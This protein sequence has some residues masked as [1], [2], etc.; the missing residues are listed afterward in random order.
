MNTRQVT[1]ATGGPAAPTRPDNQPHIRLTLKLDSRP[2]GVV[3]GAWWPHSRVLIDELPELM[4]CLDD[5]IGPVSRVAYSLVTWPAA[6]RRA[7]VGGRIVRLGGFRSISGDVIDLFGPRGR[8]CLLVIPPG[9]ASS[10]ALRAL[11]RAAAP[12]NTDDD[13]TLLRST[14]PDPDDG[15]TFASHRWETDGGTVSS[16]PEYEAP[17]G[18]AATAARDSPA[19]R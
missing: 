3:D 15:Q 8:V 9:I 4:A 11:E 12:G 2:T 14:F 13:E 10:H 5:R 6:P 1:P 18:L 19:P 16:R 17:S 7:I